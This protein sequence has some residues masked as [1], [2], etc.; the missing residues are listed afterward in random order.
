MAQHDE[1]YKLLFSHREMVEDLL[2]GFVHQP[3]V[4]NVD[5]ST[6]EPV[7]ASFVSY[8][9]REREDDL[10][11]RV[12][13][14]EEWLYVYLLLEFQSSV[15]PFMAVRI[16]VYVGLLYQDLIKLEQFTSGGRLPPVFPVVLYNGAGQ[17]T[18][19]TELSEIIESVPG[20]LEQYR[21]R[22]CY[23]LIA[24]NAYGEP[25]LAPMR[26]LAAA[27]FRLE[28]S[29]SADDIR[30]VL[31]ALIVWLADPSQDSLSRSLVT[32]LSRVLLPSRVPGAEIPQM[33]DLQEARAMLAERV[34]EWTKEWREQGLQDGRREGRQEGRQEGEAAVLTELL[35]AKFGRVE[36]EHRARIAAADGDTILRW[37]RRVLTA[38]HPEDVFA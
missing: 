4:E 1:S 7:K 15:D 6:L 12:R 34:K 17:W 25:E 21:P 5:F 37:A 19:A 3:W 33:R 29:R 9:L 8:D 36:E 18:A 24:E 20:G 22:M 28:N 16:M 31:D 32:W 26:N 13:W 10:I 14:G 35:D 38:Q 27:L 30:K 2:R 23:H 11:W